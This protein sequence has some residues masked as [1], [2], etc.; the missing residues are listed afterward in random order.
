MAA[1]SR[2]RALETQLRDEV[3]AAGLAGV[4]SV[5]PFVSDTAPLY[6]WADIV[7]A[8]SKLPES[9]G[10][11][12][13]EAMAFGRPALVSAIG[14]L[15]EVVAD[16][17]TGWHVPPG[18]A[19]ALAARLAAIVAQPESW[20]DFGR[21][22]RARYELTFSR[23]AA[24]EALGGV[25]A[26]CLARAPGS[27]AT[28]LGAGGENAM[29]FPVIPQDWR[30]LALVLGGESLQ[31][32]L[33]FALNL[34]L[35]AML[36]PQDY[37]TFAFTLVMGGVGLYYM[38]S[39]AA[40][41]ASTYIGRARRAAFGDF[42]EGAFGAAA[43]TVSAVIALVAGLMLSTFSDGPAWSGGAMVGLWSLRSHLRTVGYARRRPVAVIAGDAAFAVV[44]A[45]ASGLALSLTEDRLQNVLLALALANFA[46]SA[47]LSLCRR[48][49]PLIDFGAR[50][51]AFYYALCLQAR[52]VALQRHG[53]DPA[54]TWR[55]VPRRRPRRSRGLCADRRHARLLRAACASS[56]S[57]S[58]NMLQPEIARLAGQGDE[59]GWRELRSV[60]TLRACLIGLVYGEL[61]LPCSRGC[62]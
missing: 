12:A 26:R 43:L 51:R 15:T 14:G 45:L 37:G 28:A 49:A 5:E 34:A 47:V 13:I 41:P 29:T 1:R 46:G 54:G 3:A 25:A 10:R 57:R 56:R 58:R 6:R 60:W 53:D 38:R 17:Q 59:A 11:T 33:H 7:V 62:I 55:L 18:D 20:A 36:P 48:A 2:T 22:A 50:A 27:S 8:P 35:M 9:L 24:T 44:G 61:G 32:G 23:K 31:S 42:C 40:M 4:V 16:G 39:L 21:R 30:R 19:A 52:L